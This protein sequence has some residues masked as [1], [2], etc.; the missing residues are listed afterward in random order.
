MVYGITDTRLCRKVHHHI[1]LV[2]SESLVHQCF[3]RK[4]ALDERPLAVRIAFRQLFDF[5]KTVILQRHIVVVVAVIKTNDV[6]R[7]NGAKQ[8]HD[9]V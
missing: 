3:I 5:R 9:K 2:F 8:L 7:L 4:V 6:H 1:K